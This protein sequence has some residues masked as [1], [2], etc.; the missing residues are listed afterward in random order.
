MG[1]LNCLDICLHKPM[2]LEANKTQTELVLLLFMLLC[3]PYGISL[4][5]QLKF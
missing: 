2:V 1:S 4:N 5:S 3:K